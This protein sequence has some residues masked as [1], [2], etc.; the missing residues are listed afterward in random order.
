LGFTTRNPNGAGHVAH[1][2]KVFSDKWNPKWDLGTDDCTYSTIS[3][4]P[5]E[6]LGEFRSLCRSEIEKA[7][8]NAFCSIKKNLN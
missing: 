2:K 8:V 6:D 1:L 3:F 4:V 7:T 5:N